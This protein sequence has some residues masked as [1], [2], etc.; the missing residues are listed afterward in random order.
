MEQ[1]LLIEFLKSFFILFNA[2]IEEHTI[3][4][5]NIF[6]VISWDNEDDKQ[7]FVFKNVFDFL[8][9]SKTKSLCDYL[10]EQN[11]INGDQIIISESELIQKLNKS[12]WNETD[13]KEA[14]NCLC[15]LDV[16]MID[17]GEETDS[18]FVHF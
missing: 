13:A 4:D 9:L 5:R 7:K 3:L 18:F 15:D 17:D 2:K 6:G 1:T 8:L 16:K 14:I 11:L 12:G 10:S